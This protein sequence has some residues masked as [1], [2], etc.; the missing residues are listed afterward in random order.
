MADRFFPCRS[1]GQ[2]TLRTSSR[3]LPSC[4]ER[5]GLRLGCEWHPAGDLWLLGVEAF[6]PM[7]GCIPRATVRALAGPFRMAV[8]RSFG[9][10]GTR[11]QP[12]DLR[13]RTIRLPS[14]A[15]AMDTPTCSTSSA[16]SEANRSWST[17]DR[18]LHPG[19]LEWRDSFREHRRAQHAGPVDGRPVRTGSDRSRGTSQPRVRLI[20]WH[21]SPEHRLGRSEHRA[22]QWLPDPVVHRRRI[23]FLIKPALL[24]RRRRSR[25]ASTHQV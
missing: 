22:Y 11:R 24:D 2:T 16:S 25:R 14:R 17:G 20:S 10:L 13:H 3:Q 8:M 4:F 21:S 9:R 19:Y 5:S 1:A 23:L 6:A 12:D 15:A 18:V 7:R